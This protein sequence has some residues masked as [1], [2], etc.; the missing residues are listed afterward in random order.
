[1][2]GESVEK[3]KAVWVASRGFAKA[4]EKGKP[5]G[6]QNWAGKGLCFTQEPVKNAHNGE[7][8]L[9]W[10]QQTDSK[11]VRRLQEQPVATM[12]RKTWLERTYHQSCRS[13]PLD[14]AEHVLAGTAHCHSKLLS[15]LLTAK[16]GKEFKPF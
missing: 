3:R 11:M 6:Q 14:S 8:W 12:K 15:Q 5:Y 10:K 1:M 16:D 9:H 13:A 7:E 4:W 2:R